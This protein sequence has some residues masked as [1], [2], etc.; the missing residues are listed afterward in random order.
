M[1]VPFY[2]DQKLWSRLKTKI[3]KSKSKFKVMVS[4]MSKVISIL[5]YGKVFVHTRHTEVW[6]YARAVTFISAKKVAIPII[7]KIKL[8]VTVVVI[9]F[10]VISHGVCILTLLLLIN[11][12]KKLRLKYYFLKVVTGGQTKNCWYMPKVLDS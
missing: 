9:Y 3:F 6:T 4:K 1:K 10:N 5:V 12:Y 11:L 2:Y 8:K 7:L